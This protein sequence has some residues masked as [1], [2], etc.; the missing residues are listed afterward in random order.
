MRL[1]TPSEFGARDLKGPGEAGFGG[2]LLRHVLFAVYRVA[3]DPEHDPRP[4]RQ[5]LRQELPEYWSVRQR[6]IEL[7]RYLAS[8]SASLA[9]WQADVAAARLLLGSVEVDSV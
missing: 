5:Y 7:L 8:T 3:S 9:H 1:K 4:A 6:V 2:T